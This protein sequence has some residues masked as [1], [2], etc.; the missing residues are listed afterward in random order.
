MRVASKAQRSGCVFVSRKLLDFSSA[1]T[2]QEYKEALSRKMK[3]RPGLVLANV[4]DFNFR[5]LSAF[6]RQHDKAG[7][8]ARLTR[9][10]RLPGVF[11]F[12]TVTKN[13]D[14]DTERAMRW[15]R[16]VSGLSRKSGVALR[17]TYR[18]INPQETP[19]NMKFFS[20]LQFDQVLERIGTSSEWTKILEACRKYAVP[21][22][23][24]GPGDDESVAR[25]DFSMEDE[26]EFDGHESESSDDDEEAETRRR[27]EAARHRVLHPR[28]IIH[29]L[30]DVGD[31]QLAKE[32]LG[33]TG[34]S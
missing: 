18:L 17:T 10:N 5:N 23:D 29:P 13:F 15:M 28:P 7:T 25:S 19:S 9:P 22:G 11:I 4:A 21:S 3:N 12:F 30:Q 8:L 1:Q 2:Q 34:S 14:A 20:T 24:S 31:D 33:G 32:R 16:F 6:L 27:K 26:G